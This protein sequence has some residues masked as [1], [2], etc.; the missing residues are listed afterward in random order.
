MVQNKTMVRCDELSLLIIGI[1]RAPSLHDGELEISL[2]EDYLQ[3]HDK[4][5]GEVCQIKLSKNVEIKE[6]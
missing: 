3:L 1:R 5:T 6:A 2:G 4:D